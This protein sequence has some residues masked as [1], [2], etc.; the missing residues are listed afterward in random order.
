MKKINI[1]TN[2]FSITDNQI[3]IL[4]GILYRNL[5]NNICELGAGVSTQIF[6]YYKE[7]L[8]K[9]AN[10]VSIE[11]DN[12]YPGNIFCELIEETS[13][14]I[15]GHVF[16]CVNIY[17]GLS[18]KLAGSKFDFVL[19][20]GPFGYNNDHKYTRVQMLEFLTNDLLSNEGCFLIHDSERVSSQNTQQILYQLFEKYNYQFEI[21]TDGSKYKRLTII[22]F[23]KKLED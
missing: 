7:T 19:I 20:D 12:T 18:N 2:S 1:K 8:N 22:N 13:Y 16:D 23:R 10:I 11:H 17:N 4:L 21:R 15:D 14:C 3:D 6:K 9:N 5:P